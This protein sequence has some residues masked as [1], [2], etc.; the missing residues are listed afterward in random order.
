MNSTVSSKFTEAKQ[1]AQQGIEQNLSPMQTR[2]P[3]P[4][5]LSP[6]FFYG[7]QANP[8]LNNYPKML[9]PSQKKTYTN[10]MEPWKT[11]EI[12][13]KTEDHLANL[14]NPYLVECN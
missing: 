9:V 10:G 13:L 11:N 8:T 12:L 2:R 3:L 14:M 6:S 5:L 7:S 4:L 1:L